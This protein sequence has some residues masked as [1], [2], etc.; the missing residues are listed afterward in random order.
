[1][2][3]NGNKDY[4][5]FIASRLKRVLEICDLEVSGFAQLTGKSESHIYGILNGSRQLGDSFSKK[6]GNILN[7]D[8]GKIFNLNK[9]LPPVFD[10]SFL[11]E[12]RRKYGGNTE[13]FISKRNEDSIDYFIA[14][15][16]IASDYLENQR[17]VAE[18]RKYSREVHQKEFSS[19]ELSKGLTY[20]V[21]KGR[22]KVAKRKIVKSNGEDG[23]RLVD[24]FWK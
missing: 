10:S 2:V 15:K 23:E 16:I 22:L 19:E 8:A 20:S 7:F 21:K 3:K 17:S 18:I 11:I 24:V 9:D 6:I 14:S 4:N 1:M 13:Y 5:S 12:F